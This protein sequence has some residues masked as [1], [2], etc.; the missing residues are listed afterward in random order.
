MS[1]AVLSVRVGWACKVNSHS[2][3]PVH[4]DP[5]KFGSTYSVNEVFRV[6]LHWSQNRQNTANQ[7]LSGY[8]LQE[9]VATFKPTTFLSI[10]TTLESYAH[11]SNCLARLSA[12]NKLTLFAP[13]SCIGFSVAADINSNV[14]D[15]YFF[16]WSIA[17]SVV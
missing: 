11:C 13:D 17:A 9:R 2:L 10:A 6:H 15:F 16:I 12:R 5:V 8:T 7:H 1:A 4:L 3:G 14:F